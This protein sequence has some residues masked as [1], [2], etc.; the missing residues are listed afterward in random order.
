VPPEQLETLANR[1]SMLARDVASPPVHFIKT[2]G[3]A[4][5]LTSVDPVALLRGVLDLRAAADKY[6][7]LPQLRIGVASGMAVRRAGDWFGSPVNVASRVTA[8]A[9][10]GAVLVAESARDA[11]GSAAG[12]TW[13]FAGARHLKGVKGEVKLYRARAANGE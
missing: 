3:D 11:I 9:R 6:E 7:D 1:L 10:P 12:L 8:V 2:I 5:M 4:V 13:W